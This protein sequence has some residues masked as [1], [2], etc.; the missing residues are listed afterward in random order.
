MSTSQE[1]IDLN[2]YTPPLR[3]EDFWTRVRGSS[4]QSC[5]QC[6]GRWLSCLLLLGCFF[7]ALPA[8][9]QVQRTASR[10][11]FEDRVP[12]TVLGFLLR[13]DTRLL[14]LYPARGFASIWLVFFCSPVGSFRGDSGILDSIPP[15]SGGVCGGIESRTG[16]SRAADIDALTEMF[17]T[18]QKWILAK[19]SDYQRV[20]RSSRNHR[21]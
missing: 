3:I 9:F 20:S 14:M 17:M 13:R 10:G 11:S 1:G 4:P 21:L 15:R 16:L 5:C 7:F 8:K 6:L 2:K 12:D 19:L 18:W